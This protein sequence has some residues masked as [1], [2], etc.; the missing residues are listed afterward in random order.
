MTLLKQ[1]LLSP[2]F[3]LHEHFVFGDLENARCGIDFNSE[4]ELKQF[5]TVHFRARS[6]EGFLKQFQC[7]KD[8]LEA[9]VQAD[10]NITCKI[11]LSIL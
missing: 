4:R 7:F 11:L 8:D 1:P 2:D 3:N 6:A 9:I 10:G 5:L